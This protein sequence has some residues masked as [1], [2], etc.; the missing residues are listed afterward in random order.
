MGRRSG[1]ALVAVGVLR[2]FALLGSVVVLLL[3]WVDGALWGLWGIGAL[4]RLLRG[5]LWIR[6]LPSCWRTMVE[7]RWFSRWMSMHQV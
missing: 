3:M 6:W 5:L 4:L 1:W 7:V 2:L